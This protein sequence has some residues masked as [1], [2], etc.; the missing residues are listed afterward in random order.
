MTPTDAT[1]ED[2]VRLNICLRGGDATKLK[3]LAKKSRTKPG[4]FAKSLLGAALD[5]EAE[6]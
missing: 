6:A 4:Q 5:R 1:S 3:E 2:E